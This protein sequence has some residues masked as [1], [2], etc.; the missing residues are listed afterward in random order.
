MNIKLDEL[1]TEIKADNTT[2]FNSLNIKLSALTSKITSSFYDQPSVDITQ[3]TL[4][5]APEK[6]SHAS[7]FT[8][9]LFPMTLK[10]DTLIK[11][12]KWWYTFL[13]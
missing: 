2:T 1:K 8:K 7:Q 13:S 10:G 4:L 5:K 11:I 3:W 9:H 6:S 12:P